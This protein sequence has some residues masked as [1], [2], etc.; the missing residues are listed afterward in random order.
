MAKTIF[1]VL[2]STHPL[3][4]KLLSETPQWW[5]LLKNDSEIYFE[6]RKDSTIDIYYNGGCIIGELQLDKLGNFTWK[7]HTKYLLPISTEYLKNTE[8]R[9]YQLID[10]NK[11]DMNSLKSI[12]SNITKYYP[13]SSEKG[14][15]AK[16]ICQKESYFLDSEFAFN[17]SKN[18]R[19]DMVWIDINQKEIIF[20]ELKLPT[21]KELFNGSI[22][23][24]LIK[25]KEF[26]EEENENILAYY[27]SIFILKKQLNLLPHNLKS[28]D[29]ID[30]YK[31]SDKPLLLISKCKQEW[32]KNNTSNI[33]K[34]ASGV[35]CGVYYFGDP[36]IC[37]KIRKTNGNRYIL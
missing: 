1:D 26:I 2:K 11:L 19:I 13:N 21:N 22:T 32:I 25:Y 27:K 5:N 23:N 16:F 14:I 9:N 20:V 10:T 24:Q 36:N 7:T 30:D 37:N 4:S 17:D 6:I 12:K 35:A 3:F 33:N 18:K 34:A 15:Q 29:N 28:L 31:L 8:T